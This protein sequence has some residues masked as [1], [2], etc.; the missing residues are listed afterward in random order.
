MCLSCTLGDFCS[1][2]TEE[3]TDFDFDDY[4]TRLSKAVYPL[5]VWSTYLCSKG[6][7]D[8]TQTSWREVLVNT[9]KYPEAS[10]AIIEAKAKAKIEEFDKKYADKIID[11]ED[12]E[13]QTVCMKN[14]TEDDAY[15][16]VRGHELF[17][18]ILY[19]VLNPVITKLRNQHYA[20]LRASGTDEDTRKIALRKYQAKD[21]PVEKMLSKNYRYK[22]NTLIYKQIWADVMQIW[23]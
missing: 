17:D 18:H 13:F 10:L 14:I 7:Q 9:E 6:N 4:L 21:K 8:F 2:N 22:N 16:Y 19:S 11:K 1:E 15:L 12:F 3:A 20:V 5:L 23:E